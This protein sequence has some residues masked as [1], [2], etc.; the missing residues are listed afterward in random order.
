MAIYESVMNLNET[1][2][3][4]AKW[5]FRILSPRLHEYTFMARGE[6]VDAQRFDCVLV[7]GS[8]AVETG[9]GDMFMELSNPARVS[10]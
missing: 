10:V 6:K 7:V 8:P 1:N 5:A 9:D 4:F 2:A 3:K